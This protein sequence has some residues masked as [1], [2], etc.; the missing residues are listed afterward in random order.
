MN[1]PLTTLALVQRI[2]GDLAQLRA[3]VTGTWE[4]QHNAPKAE[5]VLSLV[6][7]TYRFPVAALKSK[8]RTGLLSFARH[9][10]CWLL[11]RHAG[12]T[13]TSAGRLLNR[14]HTS[15]VHAEERID[16]LRVEDPKF[17]ADLNKLIDRMNDVTGT[18][19]REVEINIPV[20]IKKQTHCKEAPAT[21]GFVGI[22][23]CGRAAHKKK[24]GSWVCAR[25]LGIEDR[26][27]HQGRA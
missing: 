27:A 13:T 11:R 4:Q 12:L 25:C 6:S 22:C 8:E 14:D 20:I 16:R 23:L 1:P 2:E 18:E 19:A 7:Q 21:A 9:V 24:S 5:R 17:A 3:L 26:M 10:A 15:I